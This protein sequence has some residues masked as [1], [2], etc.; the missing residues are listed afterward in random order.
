MNKTPLINIDTE[1]LLDEKKFHSI[2][3]TLINKEG[4]SYHDFKK[5][6]QPNYSKI[7]FHIATG[8]LMIV[9]CIIASLYINQIATTSL[10]IVASLADAALL[11][12]VVNY[13]SNFF[14]EAAH[15]NIAAD[16]NK[17]DIIA[18]CFLGIL[19]AQHI[20][21]YR[22]IHWQHHVHIGT[23]EDT[24]HS[25]FNA[26]TIRFFIESLT[27]ISALRIFIFRS[28]NTAAT[29][30]TATGKQQKR[31]LLIAGIIFH[32]TALATFIFFQQYW[33]TGIWIVGFGTFFPFFGSLR[34]LLEHRDERA[35]KEI[36]YSQI[37]HGRIN[38]IFS[39][40]WFAAAFGSAGFDRH[41]L[42]HLEPQ[43]SYT[44]LPELENFLQQTSIGIY[45]KKQKTSYL[46][47]F[48][49]LLGK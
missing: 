36:D 10:K 49:K 19:Q 40:S 15:Y 18:N 41:L 5:T 17:N 7:A 14:H 48:I 42:H 39:G 11:G 21:Q 6:L 33:L 31:L 26:L 30:E 43:V 25:Y 13:L 3:L 47:A 28:K 27:G 23:P 8:W 35:S 44:N 37:P 22:I 46:K 32:L 34:Q 45:L 24:E 12:F 29:K 1:N 4:I 9:I 2:K 16:K 20:K 38:R